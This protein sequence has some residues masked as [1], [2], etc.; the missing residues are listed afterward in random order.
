MTDA[1]KVLLIPGGMCTARFYDELT[2]QPRLAGIAF[3]AVTLPGFGPTAATVAPTMRAVVDFYAQAAAGADAVVGHSLGG[4]IAIELAAAR[5]FAGPIAVIEPAFSKRDEYQEILLL[6]RIARYASVGRPA[7]RLTLKSFPLTLRG[8]FP[9]PLHGELAQLMAQSDPEF[10]RLLIS[11]YLDEFRRGGS[12]VDRLLAAG[13]PAQVIFGDRSKVGL[14]A[15]E[16]GRLEAAP[17]VTFTELA[18]AGHFVMLDQPQR[19]AE[20]ISSLLS[21]ASPAPR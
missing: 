19:T 5:G 16:R 1:P 12:Y 20:L 2:T 7:W 14:T 15:D 21:A 11:D 18:D 9:K 13:N 3:D 10:C 8:E 6:D 17:S 4:N